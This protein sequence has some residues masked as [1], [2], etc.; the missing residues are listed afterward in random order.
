MIA[1]DDLLRSTGG[2]LAGTGRPQAF[3][4]FCFDSRLARPGEL[5]AAVRTD[6]ADGHDYAEQAC[7]AGVAGVLAEREL[8]LEPWGAVCVVV[9]DTRRAMQNWAGYALASRGLRT[10]GITGSVGKTTAKEAIATVLATKYPVFKN[11]AN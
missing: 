10:V 8:D 6:R 11:R 9:P 7:V 1:L 3:E 4:R 5:F 2:R